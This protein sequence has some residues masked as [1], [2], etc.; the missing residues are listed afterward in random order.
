MTTLHCHSFRCG[1]RTATVSPGTT[2]S[3]LIASV[4]PAFGWPSRQCYVWFGQLLANDATVIGLGLQS[5]DS[6]LFTQDYSSCFQNFSNYALVQRSVQERNERIAKEIAA[7]M[8]AEHKNKMEQEQKAQKLTKEKEDKEQEVLKQQCK[9]ARTPLTSYTAGRLH[10]SSFWTGSSGH[11]ATDARVTRLR[12]GLFGTT[13]SGKS[14]MI[15]TCER[16]L[17]QV[18][19]GT[20]KIASNGLEGTVFLQEYLTDSVFRLVDTRGLFYYDRSEE[21]EVADIIAGRLKDGQKLVRTLKP[22]AAAS[23]A[24]HASSSSSSK[25]AADEPEPLSD[26]MHAI[27][28]V[29][30]AADPTL[31]A[32]AKNLGPL[33][34]QW[35]AL[36]VTPLTV[37]THEDS[38]KQSDRAAVQKAC[39]EATGSTADNTFFLSNYVA[40]TVGTN[41]AID[42]RAL[43]IITRCVF[44]AECGL[45]RA[46]ASSKA[47]VSTSSQSSPRTL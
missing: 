2:I 28:F 44:V 42:L 34:T 6:V 33:R 35:K 39:C 15:A 14:S 23:A 32:L 10:P 12:I 45:Q 31:A 24:A 30:R 13:G 20:A 36:G 16:A 43:Q 4:R 40:T 21:K 7:K 25:H 46:L 9:T 17:Y 3:Q 11:P 19:R 5:G 8:E 27:V 41:H 37:I 38:M 26:R 47:P 1:S 22:A 18:S 29:F